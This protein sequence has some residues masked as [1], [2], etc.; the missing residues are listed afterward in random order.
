L[1]IYEVIDGRY[2][3]EAKCLEYVCAALSSYK[4]ELSVALARAEKAEA[5]ADA[6]FDRHGVRAALEWL[7]APAYEPTPPG[8]DIGAEI[9]DGERIKRVVDRERRDAVAEAAEENL[10][11]RARLDAFE[12]L[13]AALPRC[14]LCDSPATKAW[15]R[16]GARWCDNHAPFNCH[17]YPRAAALRELGTQEPKR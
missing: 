10:R 9:P 5:E 13:L 16:G 6:T 3:S 4:R 7:E 15:R 11:L 14:E 1:G 2:H 8:E 17:D 12:R